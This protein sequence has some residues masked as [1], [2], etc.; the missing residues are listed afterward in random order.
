MTALLLQ[1][2]ENGGITI[3]PAYGPEARH[4]D[5]VLGKKINIEL[6][7]GTPLKWKHVK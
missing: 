3:R 5:E 7:M 1:A 4:L 6:N 2:V